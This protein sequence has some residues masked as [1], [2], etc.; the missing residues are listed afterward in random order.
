MNSTSNADFPRKSSRETTC[1]LVSGN[2]KSGAAVPIAIIVELTKGMS[3]V[4]D[5]AQPMSSKDLRAEPTKVFSGGK[6]GERF[7]F[8]TVYMAIKTGPREVVYRNPYHHVYRVTAEFDGFTKTFFV[9]DYGKRVGLVI[10]SD[11]QIL[12][13]RQYRFL[14][15]E[16]AWESPGG[17]VDPGETPEQAALREG[18]EETSLRC[19]NLKPLLYF[20]PGLDTFDNPTFMFLAEEFEE[21][22]PENFHRDEVCERVWVPLEECV[23]MIFSKQI[24]DSLTIAAVL[25]YHTRKHHP[26]L[27][28]P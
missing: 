24:V 23:R 20:H 5:G 28:R 19:R 15:D 4:L 10:V 14:V 8:M 16:I 25:A 11:N 18:F 21:M 2:L 3:K 7:T 12:L 27:V 22:P 9:N 6:Y 13:V 1:P 26:E 17:K